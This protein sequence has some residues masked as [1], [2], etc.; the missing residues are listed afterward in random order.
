MCG[1]RI[2][3]VQYSQY[4]VCWCPGSLR[5]QDTNTYDIEKISIYRVEIWIWALFVIIDN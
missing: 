4:H 1:D 5:H 2:I 3:P